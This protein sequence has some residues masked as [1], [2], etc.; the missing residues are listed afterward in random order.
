MLKEKYTHCYICE[1]PHGA[2]AE[3]LRWAVLNDT[4]LCCGSPMCF[5]ADSMLRAQEKVLPG[6]GQ[7]IIDLYAGNI[8]A[9]T[10][11][12]DKKGE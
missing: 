12:D 6:V 11:Q 4:R 8:P 7:L 2:D 5:Q 9:A 3:A 1:Q 10:I